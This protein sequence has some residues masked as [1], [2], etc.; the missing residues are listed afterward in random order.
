MN[1]WNIGEKLS[2]VIESNWNLV[3]ERGFLD[4]QKWF[5]EFCIKNHLAPGWVEYQIEK[6]CL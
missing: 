6:G 3:R 4:G 5:D 1:P 2:I